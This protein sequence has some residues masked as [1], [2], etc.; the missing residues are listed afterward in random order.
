MNRDLTVFSVYCLTATFTCCLCHK[1]KRESLVTLSLLSHAFFFLF[2]FTSIKS[3]AKSADPFCILPQVLIP[4]NRNLC[5]LLFCLLSFACTHVVYIKQSK[6]KAVDSEINLTVML[7][8]ALKCWALT[9]IEANPCTLIL[10]PAST[11]IT[12][13]QTPGVGD[14]MTRVYQMTAWF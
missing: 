13:M 11:P 1:L 8:L 10:P 5:V 9:I 6:H 4:H 7:K 14:M 12:L 2:F 3:K